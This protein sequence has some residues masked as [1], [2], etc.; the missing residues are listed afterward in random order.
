MYFSKY[1]CILKMK[2][3]VPSIALE[4][5]FCCCCLVVKECLTLCD[6]ID[7]SMPGPP[8]FTISW[9]LLKFMSIEL[10]VLSNHLI[11]WRPSS[12]CLPSFPA[13]VCFPLNQVFTSG[14]QS[15]GASASSSILLMNIQDWFPLE[16][17]GL[18]SII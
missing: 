11:F 10:V 6:P 5:S 15:I 3:K 18:I 13:S 1:I 7:Y 12:F 16:L 2:W 17:T 14:S 9:S 8:S 4:H